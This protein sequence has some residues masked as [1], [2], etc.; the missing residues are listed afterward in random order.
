MQYTAC[1]NWK[2][3]FNSIE[4]LKL[5]ISIEKIT[6]RKY[7]KNRVFIRFSSRNERRNISLKHTIFAILSNVL[8][9]KLYKI[10]FQIIGKE[11]PTENS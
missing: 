7:R 5:F 3:F 2:I 4:T 1:E 8:E 9:V 10:N 6:I 11:N